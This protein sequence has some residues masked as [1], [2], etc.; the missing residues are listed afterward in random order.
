MAEASAIDSERLIERYSG[1]TVPSA[2]TCDQP[3]PEAHLKVELRGMGT[4]HQQLELVPALLDGLFALLLHGV[5][6]FSPVGS[7]LPW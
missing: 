7:D 2:R 1:G 4:G 5:W 3:K 6:A